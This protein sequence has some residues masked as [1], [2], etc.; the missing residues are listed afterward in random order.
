MTSGDLLFAIERTVTSD[1]FGA[2]MAQPNMSTR[3]AR[4]AAAVASM[5][6]LVSAAGCSSQYVAP[7]RKQLMGF[8][9][10]TEL[11]Q[12]ADPHTGVPY[13][14]PCNP[15]S[16]PTIKTPT[17]VITEEKLL[18]NVAAMAKSIA[19]PISPILAE[20]RAPI[21]PRQERDPVETPA[22]DVTE[23]YV[24]FGTASPRLDARGLN[25]VRNLAVLAKT[26]GA[27][28]VTG[29]TDNTGT[30]A[31]NRRLALSRAQTVRNALISAGVPATKIQIESCIDCYHSSNDTKDGRLLNRRAEISFINTSA[32]KM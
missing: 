12:V 17:V 23:N 4:L 31:G 13:F 27:I 8:P 18:P 20:P 2:D 28:T 5:V 6:A 11:A 21:I 10:V 16:A 24:L 7:P 3:I 9:T 25:T 1:S 32:R 29:Q 14:S 19:R 26:A 15:C 22:A 30:S